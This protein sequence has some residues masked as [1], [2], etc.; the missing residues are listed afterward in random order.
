MQNYNQQIN[1]KVLLLM[2]IGVLYV[3]AEYISMIDY[4]QMKKFFIRLVLN[5]IL[6]QIEI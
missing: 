3:M 2:Q 5:V 1:L 4:R 6:I